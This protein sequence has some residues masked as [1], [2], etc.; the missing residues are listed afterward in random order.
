M[1]VILNSKKEKVVVIDEEILDIS[2]YPTNVNT[3]VLTKPSLINKDITLI[4]YSLSSWIIN[5][6]VSEGLTINNDIIDISISSGQSIQLRFDDFNQ[7]FAI[8]GRSNSVSGGSTLDGPTIKALYSAENK[9]FTDNLFDKLVTTVNGINSYL[10][11]NATGGLPALNASLLTNLN[12][13]NLSS[14]TVPTN[15][16]P[17]A[18][19]AI[20]GIT[21]LY[22]ALSNA[23]DGAVANNVINLLSKFIANMS[24]HI[25]TDVVWEAGTGSPTINSRIRTNN[26]IVIDN[27]TTISLK[28]NISDIS[29]INTDIQSNPIKYSLILSTDQG[30][31][32]FDITSF[33]KS[34]MTFSVTVSSNL[35]TTTIDNV[36]IYSISVVET[37]SIAQNRAIAERLY[38]LGSNGNTTKIDGDI[39][40]ESIDYI[41]K[42]FAN[43]LSVSD[44]HSPK[45][46]I[47]GADKIQIK[48]ASN[49]SG[50]LLFPPVANSYKLGAIWDSASN[51]NY[52]T[53]S[54][55]YLNQ[56]FIKSV[57]L[58][59]DRKTL[60]TVDGRNIRDIK[61]WETSIAGETFN[62]GTIVY[63]N[64]A[65]NKYYTATKDD[66][67]KC[68]NLRLSTSNCNAGDAATAIKFGTVTLS[69]ALVGFNQ[70]LYLSNFGDITTTVPTTG[71]V[72]RIG[73]S[74]TNAGGGLSYAII[75]IEPP[76]PSNLS[77]KGVDTFS[78]STSLDFG[79]FDINTIDYANQDVIISAITNP[80][81]K[82]VLFVIS[83]A[84]SFSFSS[85]LIP[86][87]NIR[88]SFKFGQINYLQITYL[89]DSYIVDWLHGD[90]AKLNIKEDFVAVYNNIVG[91]LITNYSGS[92]VY[93]VTVNPQQVKRVGVMQLKTG[94]TATGRFYVG[95][96]QD[97]FHFNSYI[98]SF[99]QEI[100]VDSAQ[101]STST[102]TYQIFVGFFDSQSNSQMNYGFYFLYDPQGVDSR[103]TSIVNNW[104]CVSQK[105]GGAGEYT[106]IN[107]GV[108]YPATGGNTFINFK[109]IANALTNT[110]TYYI[111]NAQ[112]AQVTNT[113]YLPL[114]DM[115]RCFGA[116]V[117][118]RK[119]VGS[120]ERT[121]L[122]DSC[123]YK[124]L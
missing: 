43:G 114:T 36:S 19:A 20:L 4:N 55:Q 122:V 34:T 56:N 31:A 111:N 91:R 65:D 23:T 59:N 84:K 101:A 3:T 53:Y 24:K 85:V 73:T 83:N 13:N 54:A 72:V 44:K 118:L 30:V 113:A 5:V 123:E 78:T 88:G 124:I 90:E 63:L 95:T 115:Y 35:I 76:L 119:N 50:E 121:V 86:S 96:N 22:T 51:Q 82:S 77:T 57:G 28:T 67:T 15:R 120:T 42:L 64:K 46:G 80:K 6:D 21:K 18:T 1:K 109:I 103:N 52:L 32:F 66:I 68:R 116:G 108:A 45:F 58:I 99:E 105:G 98:F 14:G 48:D 41:L 29:D 110:V 33:V 112:V 117:L 74:F 97:A 39:T 11:L 107:S 7:N 104:K 71:E 102:D 61:I 9:A 40:V 38:V 93:P 70:E 25:T 94:N 60:E 89:H 87:S 79:D 37:S 75:D 12:A 69:T 27:I 16:L 49:N 92:N 81:K 106:Y 10:Q 8:S 17:V 100:A 47:Y 26:E 2:Q 62:V